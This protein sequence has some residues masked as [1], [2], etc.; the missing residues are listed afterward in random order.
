MFSTPEGSFRNMNYCDGPEY[1]PGC[2]CIHAAD[3][4]DPETG[5]CL[6]VN[7]IYGPCPCSAS[8]DWDERM[9]KWKTK[10]N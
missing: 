1:P 3:C 4:H 6:M 5:A 10:K 9:R 2:D 7:P 8:K